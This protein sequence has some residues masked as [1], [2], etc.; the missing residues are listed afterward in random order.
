MPCAKDLLDFSIVWAKSEIA[1]NRGGDYAP[2]PYGHHYI[3]SIGD[4]RR[5]PEM[6]HRRELMPLRNRCS[7]NSPDRPC[8][9]RIRQETFLPGSI[10]LASP[11]LDY[12][13]GSAN[14]GGM[15]LR[16][17][18]FCFSSWGMCVQ[19]SNLAGSNAPP[20]RC[21]GSSLSRFRE[22]NLLAVP[23]NGRPVAE[24]SLRRAPHSS[25]TCWVCEA[26]GCIKAGDS[27]I[28]AL[29]AD[30]SSARKVPE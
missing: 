24:M 17:I 27:A 7:S 3:R 14:P 5:I 4:C 19:F 28:S 30:A 15:T 21:R 23:V 13:T 22:T 1:A 29:A 25:P 18:A 16:G 2:Q 10:P 12:G 6:G 9:R 26:G 11:T 8:I 20:G